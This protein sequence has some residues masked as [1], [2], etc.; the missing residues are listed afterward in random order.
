MTIQQLESAS[1][2][3]DSPG[4]S[5]PWFARAQE[6]LKS[7]PEL[8]YRALLGQ[9]HQEGFEVG[10]MQLLL[11]HKLTEKSSGRGL[12]E[13]AQSQ[14]RGIG[15]VAKRPISAGTQLLTEKPV[16]RTEDEA[17]LCPLA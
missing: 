4:D 13:L 6:L 17:K 5:E 10:L 16:L 8:G 12:F 7:T 11:G 9:L 2:A 3:E 1:A 14:G 15:V